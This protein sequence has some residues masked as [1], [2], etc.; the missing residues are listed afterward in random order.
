MISSC[1]MALAMGFTGSL[2]C[3]GMCGPIMMFM[4]FYHFTGF[5]RGLAI[6]LYHFSR[7][8][9]YVLMALTLHS[10]RSAFNP[11]VQQYLSVGLGSLLLVAGL[12][13]FLPFQRKLRISLP[14]SEFVKKQLGTFVG[15]PGLPSIAMSG[16]LN[17]LLPCGLVYMA[18]S[19]SLSLHTTAQTAMFTYCFGL[20]TMPALVSIILFKN[21]L[22][23]FRRANFKALTPVVVFSMGCLFL[24]RG[25]DLGIPY[26][27][28]K[29]QV[30]NGAIHS[31]C[32]KK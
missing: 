22:S 15:N 23:F 17:G 24:L 32:H 27:S 7:I 28:P 11:R 29:V 20:G 16:M 8:S 2:H 18:L 21:R 25:L 3:V 26:L 1:I 12:M 13:S 10:F 6:G 31:C 30:S 14:W 9:V 5:R 4:P 19:A